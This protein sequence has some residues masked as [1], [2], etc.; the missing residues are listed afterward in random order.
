LLSAMPARWLRCCVAPSSSGQLKA[1]CRA[2]SARR[3]SAG[4][5]TVDCVRP[6]QQR[7]EVDLASKQAYTSLGYYHR[8]S[9]LGLAALQ[10][11]DKEAPRSRPRAMAPNWR[12]DYVVSGH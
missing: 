5:R 10:T 2:A 7:L 3:L 8:W 11:S 12:Q 4:A 9:R 6:V 1:R